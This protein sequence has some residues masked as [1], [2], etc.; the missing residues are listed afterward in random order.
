MGRCLEFKFIALAVWALIMGL[1]YYA[2]AQKTTSGISLLVWKPQGYA[3]GFLLPH[4]A[5]QS[6]VQSVNQYLEKSQ[7]VS[8][9]KK[10]WLNVPRVRAQDLSLLDV[11]AKDFVV[12]LQA[13]RAAD[14]EPASTRVRNFLERFG[15]AESS[16]YI[17]PVA[18]AIGL[19][20]DERLAF[21]KLVA[22]KIPFLVAMGG[23][24]VDPRYYREQNRDAIDPNST[25]DHFEI[26]LI[27]T[28]T[29]R[30]RGF[31]FGVCRGHQISSVAL[32]LRLHQ[33]VEKELAPPEAHRE[34]RYHE[35]RILPTE[36]NLLR[37][38]LQNRLSV[39]VNSLHHQAVLWQ[40]HPLLEVSA[41]S[42]S[43][44][45]EAV[46]FKNQRGILTQ[47]HPELMRNADG[48]QMMRA[49]SQMAADQTVGSCR[50]VYQ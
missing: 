20:V 40:T 11:G 29:Q 49:I 34:N 22:E 44:V 8:D 38:V 5:G 2:F 1:H 33:D 26:S 30:A 17:L 23:D 36:N 19:S 15:V 28:F 3:V 12:A 13:N 24:D 37:K 10:F 31:L 18:A 9:L 21:E 6:P 46:E 39:P 7:S 35:V 41:L 27:R 50:R 16:G 14:H 25:R 48:D 4:R 47:F 45:V 32:G 42:S 43:G